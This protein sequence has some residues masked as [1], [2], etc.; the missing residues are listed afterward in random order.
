[1][2]LITSA[3]SRKSAGKSLWNSNSVLITTDYK[4]A[5]KSLKLTSAS[6]S[7]LEAGKDVQVHTDD[8]L[9]SIVLVNKSSL[10]SDAFGI[11]RDQIGPK[12]NL[13]TEGNPKTTT[14]NFIG[15]NENFIKGAIVGLELAA[16]RYQ[17]KSLI[18]LKHVDFQNE[19]KKLA[20]KILS[21]ASEHAI[22]INTARH[23]VNMPPNELHPVSYAKLV[24]QMF[25]NSKSVKVEIWDEKRLA[26]EKCGLHLGVGAG[27]S[28]PP[29]L[30]KLVYKGSGKKKKKAAVV[31]KGITFD[32]GGLDL[33]PASGMRLMK[34]DMG[35]SATIVGFFTW[36][37]KQKVAYDVEGYLALAEN[38]VDERATRPSD[39]H[40]ARNGLKVEIDNTDA[41]GRLVLADAL[42]IAC[43]QKPDFIIDAATLTGAGKVALGQDVASLFANDDALAN[44]LLKAADKASDPA[45]R[46][47]LYQAYAKD[48]NSSFADC[49]NS[50]STGFG[51]S[52]TAALFLEK[53]VRGIPWAHLDIFAWTTSNQ[54]AL[55]QKGGSGQSVGALIEFFSQLELRQHHE[56]AIDR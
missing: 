3:F 1:M 45:W 7:A 10:K 44:K 43:D 14:V 29:R 22:G 27:A 15:V 32:T 50:S 28:N 37:E 9:V 48:L 11:G 39:I 40:I 19:S 20:T 16:Y 47:P 30:V 55:I 56:Q 41:E 5:I 34:K 49:V 54:P 2:S 23:L 26:K 35:G 51:G 46:M 42:D 17:E 31:G 53:F 6:V 52:I 21:S 36:L 18:G 25:K 13:L 8:G 33:K 24:Q 38:A 12:I 4:K